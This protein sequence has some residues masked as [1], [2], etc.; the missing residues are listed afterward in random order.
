MARSANK[1]YETSEVWRYVDELR[2]AAGFPSDGQFAIAAGFPPSSLSDWKRGKHAMSS[3]NLVR[4]IRAAAARSSTSPFEAG[5]AVEPLVAIHNRLAALEAAEAEKAT[6]VD[7]QKGF[8]ALEKAIAKQAPQRKR[9]A[10]QKR[11]AV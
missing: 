5:E 10:A 9:E 2:Q 4:L 6:A 8:Q 11:R 1:S 3:L 7:V